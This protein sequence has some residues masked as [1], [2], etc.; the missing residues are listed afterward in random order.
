MNDYIL[1]IKECEGKDICPE[2]GHKR[3]HKLKNKGKEHG[4]PHKILR[5]IPIITRI[6]RLFH[7]KQL[8]MF[9]GWHASH[10]S[11]PI[12]MRILVDLRA[13]KYI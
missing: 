10:R 1:Y 5:H 7:C 2:C 9:Q 3:Y 11:E 8:S 12:F 13:M 6:Q 4:P